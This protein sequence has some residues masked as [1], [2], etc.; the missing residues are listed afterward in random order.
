MMVNA[1]INK[2]LGKERGTASTE[3]FK[4]ILSQL[5][6][7]LQTLVRRVLKAKADY[8]GKDQA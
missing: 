1:E 8:D 2:R 4:Q 3:E 7:I 6:N 5:D